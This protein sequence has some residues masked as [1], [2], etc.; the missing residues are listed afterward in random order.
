MV[1]SRALPVMDEQGR[2]TGYLG[3]ATDIS[4]QH[5]SQQ[6]LRELAHTLAMRVR[7]LNCLFGISHLVEAAGG[8][9][10]RILEG[11]VELLPPSWQF[12]DIAC[13]RIAMGGR[14]YRTENFSNCGSK[15]TGDILV[16]GKQA[17]IVEV[18]YLEGKDAADEGP[19]LTEERKLID[20]IAA[21]LGEIAAHIETADILRVR[22]AELRERLRFFSRISTMGQMATS[23]AHELN[24]PLTTISSFA[25]ACRRKLEGDISDGSNVPEML[26]RIRD[27]AL[28]AG[29]IIHGLRE[30]V[31]KRQSHRAP[32]HVNELVHNVAQLTSP[33]L[34]LHDVELVLRMSHSLAPVLADEIQV[35]QVILNLVRNALEAVQSVSP[36]DR[37]DRRVVV[38]TAMNEE[39]EIVVRVADSGP[40]LPHDAAGQIFEPFFTTKEHGTGLGLAISRSIV[41]SHGGSIWHQQ[42]SQDGTTFCF[43]LPVHRADHDT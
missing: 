34:R 20:T 9:L 28:S 18:G 27:E 43:T 19:F 40:G 37:E 26:S 30:L 12:P 1:S 25:E 41:I 22:E 35:Q 11:T 7:E 8:S 4:E 5:Q 17:G 13:A 10:E 32:C 36:S 33:D 3:A 38:A 24:Q 23:I 15:L 31:E 14:E 39:G 29:K 16:R 21:R 6:S 42:D 2:L